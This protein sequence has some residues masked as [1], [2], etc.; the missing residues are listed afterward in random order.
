MQ[1]APTH[2]H[3][4]SP[5]ILCC[6]VSLFMFSMSFLCLCFCVVKYFCTFPLP[7][8]STHPLVGTCNVDVSRKKRKKEKKKEKK[9]RKKKPK[10][11]NALTSVIYMQC[12]P[13]HS[14]TQSLSIL[15]CFV[16]LFVFSISFLCFC[17]VKYFC[18]FPLPH[19]STHP[20][21]GTCT[22]DVSRRKKPREKSALTCMIY[23]QCAPTHS[24]TL[25]PT[26]SIHFMLL[27]CLLYVP[28]CVFVALSTFAPFHSHTQAHTHWLGR[29]MYM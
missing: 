8:T 23:M 5:S 29:V 4:Q 7:H 13:T 1:C 9:R 3:T 12:A 20:L 15:C 18:T 26:I 6:F 24:H 11:K 19:T 25:T 21:V 27:L 28:F 14:H 2:S 16:S 22:V 17:V 10:R